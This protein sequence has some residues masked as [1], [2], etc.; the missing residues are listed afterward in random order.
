MKHGVMG[1][2][3]FFLVAQTAAGQEAPELRRGS[4]AAFQQATDVLAADGSVLWQAAEGE[5]VRVRLVREGWAVVASSLPGSGEGRVPVA[6]LRLASEEEHMRWVKAADSCASAPTV[7]TPP[8]PEVLRE[9]PS[10]DE[11]AALEAQEPPPCGPAPPSSPLPVPAVQGAVVGW[12]VPGRAAQLASLVQV[13]DGTVILAGTM[14]EA[15][16]GWKVRGWGQSEPPRA[17]RLTFL[18]RLPARLDGPPELVMFSEQELAEPRLLRA[19]GGSVWLWAHHA[20]QELGGGIPGA[21]SYLLRFDPA[22]RRLERLLALGAE[23]QDFVVDGAGRPVVLT[24]GRPRH[25]GAQLV[26]YYSQGHFLRPWND[27]PDGGPRPRIPLDFSSPAL[28]E[29]PFALWARG[30][31]TL[32][33]FPTPLGPWGAEPNAGQPIAWTNVAA[34]RNP[35]RDA[36]LKPEALAI[37][38]DGQLLVCGTIPFH[39]GFPDFDPFLLHFSAEGRLLWANCFLSG[40]LSEPDQKT[41]ALAV[42][43]I[44]GDILVCYW[45]HGNNVQTLL[46]AP[47][48]WLNRFTGTSGNIKITWL[49]RVEAKTGRL[50]ASTYLYARKPEQRNPNWPDLNSV[51]VEDMKVSLTQRVFL[52]GST[53]INL[54]TTSNAMI[55]WVGEGGVHPMLVVLEPGLHAPTYS[56]Y[57]SPG[58]GD[59]THVAVLGGEVALIAGTHQ[60]TGTPLPV[61]GL[62]NFDWLSAEPPAGQDQ[63]LFLAIIPIPDQV[64][65]WSFEN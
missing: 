59:A 3:A 61:R 1:L 55:P 50:K 7:A 32:P 39:M 40:L 18:A 31:E 24:R 26:R 5:V 4:W 29:G 19:G 47:D 10:E 2:V 34:G 35:I 6:A 33:D 11:V 9:E 58:Q 54:P 53:T 45:Q 49:G 20:G 57:L 62:E 14:E 43:P 30:S 28:A 60:T 8:K 13:P 16:G 27:S 37:Q 41:Q 48:G 17:G 52:V 22:L 63:G 21:A 44:S 65:S 36:D 46:L 23:P 12:F 42:D 51:G 38:H 56:T 15:A 64:P 25:G